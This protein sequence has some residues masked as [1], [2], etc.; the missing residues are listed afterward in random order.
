MENL[1]FMRMLRVFTLSL[2]LASPLSHA[3][4]RQVCTDTVIAS[5]KA[6]LELGDENTIRASAC[7][8]WPDDESKMLVAIAY[9]PAKYPESTNFELPL[10]IV[11][12]NADALKILSH[13]KGSISEDAVTHV[14]QYSLEFDTGR[15]FLGKNIRAFGL[16]IHANVEP[17]FSEGG[18]DD[19][20]SLYVFEGKE[21]RPFYPGFQCAIGGT[22]EVF[23]VV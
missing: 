9:E 19:Y 16:K 13:Y 11:M 7:K 6:T 23:L 22:R 4:I 2:V 17:R 10:Q 12:V 14:E 21:I 8:Q 5:L 1:R 18:A 20:L 3:E 15:Y